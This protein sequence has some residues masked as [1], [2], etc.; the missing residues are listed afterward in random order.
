MTE[1]VNIRDAP[2]FL[3]GGQNADAFFNQ[4]ERNI[5]SARPVFEICKR[6]VA[7][8]PIEAD[9]DALPPFNVQILRQLPLP[10]H[11]NRQI[12]VVPVDKNKYVPGHADR[13]RIRGTIGESANLGDPLVDIALAGRSHLGRGNSSI[14]RDTQISN[15]TDVSNKSAIS[16]GTRRNDVINISHGAALP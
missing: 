16:N 7:A 6:L 8:W 14:R 1:Q 12:I 15:G 4:L 3:T 13:I 2:G 9:D 5:R 11:D 10:L